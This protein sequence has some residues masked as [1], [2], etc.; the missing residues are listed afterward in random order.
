MTKKKGDKKI[1]GVKSAKV[2]TGIEGTQ[3]VGEVSKVKKAAQVSA[4]KGAGA[5]KGARVDNQLSSADR[6]QIFDMIGEEAEKLFGKSKQREVV[7]NAVKMAIDAG[8]IDEEE[9]S[10][11]SGK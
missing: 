8:I 9:E 4:V 10:S 6:D 11:N 1:G 2:T 7:E 5:V 3:Q